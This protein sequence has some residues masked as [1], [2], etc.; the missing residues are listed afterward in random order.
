[1]MVSQMKRIL[2]VDDNREVTG[3]LQ[4]GIEL[5]GIEV[6]AYNNPIE[7]V[8]HFKA[9]AYDLILLDFRMPGMNG[10]QVYRELRKTDAKV[11]ICFLTAF[12]V[13]EREFNVLFPEI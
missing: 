3:A 5:N 12:D 4:A 2:V 9:G 7:A 8:D 13:Y 6:V 11:R 1:M 10:F